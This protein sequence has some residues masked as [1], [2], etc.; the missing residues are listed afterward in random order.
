[1]FICHKIREKVY[2]YFLH[3][4]YIYILSFL[5]SFLN[6]QLSFS[7]GDKLLVHDR[8]SDVWWWAELHGHFGYV[9]SSYLHKRVE[10]VED[11]WQ[12][13]EYFGNYGTLVSTKML[14]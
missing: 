12:D 9:P 3:N 5:L 1:M 10:D 8:S 7:V 13:D 4:K 6:R 14:S 11:A 2:I